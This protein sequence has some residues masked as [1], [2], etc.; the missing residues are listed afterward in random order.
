M[1][2]ATQLLDS[3]LTG[4]E[5]DHDEVADLKSKIRGLEDDNRRL[6]ATIAR[7]QQQAEIANPAPVNAHYTVKQFMVALAARRRCTYGWKK[8]YAQA[9]EET[10]DCFRV[11][12]DDIQKWQ[13]EDRVP[14]QAFVQIDWLRY[15]VRTG[16][17]PPKP[18]WSE[19]NLEY[20][21]REYQ[22]DPHQ[23]NAGLAKKCTAHFGRT[24][25]EQAIKGALFR[26]GEANRLPKQRPPK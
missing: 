15:P 18:N 19:D 2:A 25:S 22:A 17:S 21:I 20:L 14:E 13:K 23:P 12:T 8:D 24:I 9:T 1:D 11:S 6:Q 26:L 3:P 5:L 4:E 7:L 10:P 16:K